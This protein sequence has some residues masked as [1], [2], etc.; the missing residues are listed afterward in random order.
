M[1]EA[2]FHCD[3]STAIVMNCLKL[4]VRDRNRVA[5]DDERNVHNIFY[6]Y[7]FFIIMGPEA[8]I[9]NSTLWKCFK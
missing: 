7:I 8:M 1:N 3:S 5:C 2:I 4:E 9:Y 6:I